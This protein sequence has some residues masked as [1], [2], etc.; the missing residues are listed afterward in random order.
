MEILDIYENP[1]TLNNSILHEGNTEN[2]PE[3]ITLEKGIKVH[4]KGVQFPQKSL[5]TPEILVA[6]NTIKR[7]IIS[8]SSSFLIPLS[9]KRAIKSFNDI[10]WSIMTH[11]ILKDEYMTDCSRELKKLIYNFLINFGINEEDSER[12]SKIISH[13]FE[14]DNAYRLRLQDIL[15]SVP[16]HKLTS[17][18][19]I[20]KIGKL[21]HERD[22]ADTRQFENRR[23]GERFLK[24]SKL[25]SY[26]LYIPKVRR[27]LKRSLEI[28]NYYNFQMDLEDIYWSYMR[29]DYNFGGL[30]YEERM[31]KFK[32]LEFKLPQ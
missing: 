10:S 9:M 27:S 31:I 18:K 13:I 7:I 19:E 6:V 8:F 11:Y 29:K 2:V 20:R 3:F 28:C 12:C 1:K 4:M 30:T 16:R 26:T 25:I 5:P 17:P 23:V 15:S 21:L 32:E 24:I 22:D 14:Y